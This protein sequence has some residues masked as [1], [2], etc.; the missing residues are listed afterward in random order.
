LVCCIVLVMEP[1]EGALDNA[2]QAAGEGAGETQGQAVAT[3]GSS[4]HTSVTDRPHLFTIWLASAALLVS[5]AS[6][7]FT[8][9]QWFEAHAAR[10]R[11]APTQVVERPRLSFESAGAISLLR[12]GTG[13]TVDLPSGRAEQVPRDQHFYLYVTL[14]FKNTGR[15]AA[16]IVGCTYASQLSYA[17]TSADPASAKSMGLPYPQS[18]QEKTE[19]QCDLRSNSGTSGRALALSPGESA[20]ILISSVPLSKTEVASLKVGRLVLLLV[21]AISYEDSFHETLRTTWMGSAFPGA[22]FNMAYVSYLP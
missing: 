17:Y 12:G 21:G 8:G 3:P 11:L 4:E 16:S 20:E 9:L 5:A 10:N 1:E 2:P 13:I 15:T 7:F 19:Y 18:P 14:R 6:A 22:G